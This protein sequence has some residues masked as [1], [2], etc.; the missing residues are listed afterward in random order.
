MG[1]I[2][3]VK[4]RI[5]LS[6]SIRKANERLNSLNKKCQEAEQKARNIDQL[7]AAIS[8]LNKEMAE[9]KIALADIEKK[10]QNQKSRINRASNLI[11]SIVSASENYSLNGPDGSEKQLIQS[12][13]QLD[14][15]I[16]IR[17]PGQNL[18]EIRKQVSDNRK[19]IDDLLKTYQARYTTKANLTIYSLLVI[20]LRAEL[21]NIIFNLK[22]DRLDKAITSVKEMARKYLAIVTEGNQQIAPT[23]SRFIGQIEYLF[24]ES[25]KI[26]Y[27][28]FI[29]QE[30]IREEQRAIREQ[31]RQEAEERRILEQQRKQ[32]ELE[33]NKYLNEIEKI[34]ELK[35]Q[36]D[37]EEKRLACER[38]L[39]ELNAMIAELES[40][41]SEIIKLQNGQ[42]GSVYI[43]SNL[44]SFGDQ[45][46]KIGMTRRQA[47]I[48][49]INELGDASV[50]FSF[51]I[52]AMIFS[53]NAVT[54][55]SN[56]HA[57]FNESRVNKINRRKEFF[58]VSI[59]ELQQFVNEIDPSAEFNTTMLAEQFRQTMAVNE[60]IIKLTEVVEE[61]EEVS[62]PEEENIA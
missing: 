20:A 49:R 62:E 35:S 29:K 39:S 48:D 23:I 10:S 26:E 3:N 51:D 12:I 53:D 6:M 57:H 45:V 7:N 33:E 24:I 9:S 19:L 59:E 60:G 61:S 46:F 11:K 28:Y 44:G 22:F 16:L 55:E 21:Q 37:T 31:M 14:P 25:I 56:I 52:H 47:P 58:Q 41:K 40:K 27:E 18:K 42:A 8:A 32:L 30:Q 17:T 54:M 43:I 36:A 2:E 38:R 50:P 4:E 15:T 13:E 1:F 5:N 34:T